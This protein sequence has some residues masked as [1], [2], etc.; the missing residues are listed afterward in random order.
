VTYEDVHAGDYVLG[1]DG[2]MWGVLA[3]DHA[4]Q[5]AVTLVRPG[6][7][8]TGYP[9]AHTPVTIV[10]RS[11][12]SAEFAAAQVLADAGLGPELVTEIWQP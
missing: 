12:I 8:V 6:H 9:P 7:Q 3:I 1:H 10:A 2:E 5:L 4:P 11:D